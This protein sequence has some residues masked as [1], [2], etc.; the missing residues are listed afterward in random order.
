VDIEKIIKVA[1]E[2]LAEQ[3]GVKIDYT[4]T[5]KDELKEPAEAQEATA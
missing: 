1:L 4:L 5:R 2:L 3:E